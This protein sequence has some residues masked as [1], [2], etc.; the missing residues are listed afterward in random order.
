MVTRLAKI[1]IVFAFFITIS[2]CDKQSCKKVTCGTGLECVTGKCVC[3]DGTEGTGCTVASYVKYERNSATWIVS[4]SCSPIAPFQ[5]TNVYIQH[6]P[7]SLQRLFIYNL[8]NGQCNPLVAYIYTNSNNEG[9]TLQIPSQNQNCSGNTVSGTGSY[10]DATNRIYLQIDF[11]YNNGTDYQCT[12]TL[13]P[14]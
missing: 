1:F 10:D 9:N 2:S 7:A 8:F 5:S 13:Y 12:E 6:D 3:A 11:T 4:E 14:Q